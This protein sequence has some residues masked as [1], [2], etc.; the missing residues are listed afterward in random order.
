MELVEGATLADRIKSGPIPVD[1]VV[2][3]AK[4]IAEGLEYAHERGIVHRDLKPANVKVSRDDSVKILDFGLAKA[5]EGEAVATRHSQ[6]PT[7]TGMATQAGIII[8]TAPYMSPEQ[9]KGQAGGPA[10]GHLG[11]WLR[12]LR[13]ADGQDGIRRRDGDGHSG[14]GG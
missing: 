14:G 4:Q 12:S 9:A 8:G 2:L 5:V 7:L 3:I 13:N 11:V 1:E 6:S 10:R